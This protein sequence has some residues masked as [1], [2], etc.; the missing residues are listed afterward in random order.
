M[1]GVD[2]RSYKEKLTDP[3]WQRVRLEVFN[4]AGFACEVCG[5]KSSTLHA[6]HGTYFY[7]ID[8]WDIP[9]ESKSAG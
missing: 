7:G 5:D 1:S 4:R 9:I 8:P 2:T 3:R 6:H